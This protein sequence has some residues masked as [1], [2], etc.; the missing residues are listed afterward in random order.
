[1]KIKYIS[2]AIVA[3]AAFVLE[4]CS[5]GDNV[6]DDVFDDTTRGAA[7]RTISSAFPDIALGSTDATFSGTFEIQADAS[8]DITSVEVYSDFIDNT[9]DDGPGDDN[10]GLV[11]TVSSFTPTEF[12]LPGFTYN[13]AYSEILSAT[14]VSQD[15]IN[16]GDQFRLRFVLVAADGRTFG[17]PQLTGTLTG[18]YFSSPFQYTASVICPPIAP[19]P[20]DWTFVLNDSYGDSWNGASLTVTIDGEETEL[21]H[22]DGD[23]TTLTVAVPTGATSI[24]IV[25]NGGTYDGENSFTVTSANGEVVLNLGPSPDTSIGLL[26]YCLPLNL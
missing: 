9:D 16:A 13:G 24:Q 3:A 12:G 26:D 4:G 17:V 23:S 21:T 18:G 2:F 19:T 1:M 11:A 6:I 10:S 14:G 20:G 22:P 5:E 8:A 15:A 7:L 25:Y